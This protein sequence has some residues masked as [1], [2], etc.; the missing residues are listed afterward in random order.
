MA[1][2]KTVTSLNVRPQVVAAIAAALAASGYLSAGGQICS[3]RP[4]KRVNAWKMAG[5][6]ELMLGRDLS[7]Y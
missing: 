1:L 3:I 5:L 6:R 7:I 2:N 4:L